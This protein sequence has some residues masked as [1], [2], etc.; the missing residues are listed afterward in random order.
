MIRAREVRVCRSQLDSHAERIS[1]G[2]AFTHES[3]RIRCDVCMDECRWRT[4]IK[5]VGSD[6]V[7]ATI[8]FRSYNV[9]AECASDAQA[10]YMAFAGLC[11]CHSGPSQ[12]EEISRRAEPGA[13]QHNALCHCDEHR[14]YSRIY[15]HENGRT[16][17]SGKIYTKYYMESG[18]RIVFVW[19][20]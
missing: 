10:E 16:N 20:F 12:V 9:D 5:G 8:F 7:C 19:R 6:V 3:R 17:E 11:A 13:T 15:V 14:A 18:T 4:Q 1:N 2:G